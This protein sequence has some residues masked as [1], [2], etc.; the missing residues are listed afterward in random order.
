[1]LDYDIYTIRLNYLNM[2]INELTFYINSFRAARQAKTEIQILHKHMLPEE[3]IIKVVDIKTGNIT[4]K[5]FQIEKPICASK[6]FYLCLLYYRLRLSP[7]LK[8]RQVLY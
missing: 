4:D 3:K 2:P 5:L 6:I 7:R 8:N 1:M